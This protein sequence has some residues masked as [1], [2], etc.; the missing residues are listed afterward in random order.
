V[1]NLQVLR[2][3]TKTLLSIV[4][5]A[6][7]EGATI[8]YALKRVLEVDYPCAVEI[9]VV[10][11]GSRDDTAA[12][13]ATVGDQRVRVET[14]RSNRGKGA[15]VLTGVWAARGSHLLVFDADLEYDPNDIPAL[16]RPVLSRRAK[17]V[18]GSRI[19]GIETAY[20]SL[21]YAI[22]NRATTWAANILFNAYMKDLHTCLKLIPLDLIRQLELSETGFG[23]DTEVTAKILRLGI[24]PYEVPVSY[25]SR[26]RD[27]GK[28]ITWRDGFSCMNILL[29]VRR[30]ASPVVRYS[31]A[32]LHAQETVTIA[33]PSVSVTPVATAAKPVSE[34]VA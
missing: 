25:Y 28:K 20:H 3:E 22:G 12:L 26:S 33:G 6:Y 5:P 18:Y 34:E 15:A 29:R 23:L 2:G 8:M 14:H 16:L 32:R 24:R 4:M 31:N 7:N 1:P 9:I 21:H 19:Q 27:E 10:N 17:V 13:L 11:D 30:S